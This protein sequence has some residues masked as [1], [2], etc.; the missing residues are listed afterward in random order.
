MILDGFNGNI[1]PV[2]LLRYSWNFNQE[3]VLLFSVYAVQCVNKYSKILPTA[4]LDFIF[5]Q[6][7]EPVEGNDSLGSSGVEVDL[8]N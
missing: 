2:W 6:G 1:V 3:I 7:N 5:S 8:M 4:Y